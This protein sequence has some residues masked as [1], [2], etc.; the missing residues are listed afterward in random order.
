M[1]TLPKALTDMLEPVVQLERLEAWANK[2]SRRFFDIT[3]YAPENW[4][5]TL[6]PGGGE[7]ATGA[8]GATLV[9]VVRAAFDELE[10]QE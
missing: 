6:Y 5:V 7:D 2:D 9:E 1:S 3:R 4:S 8:F 10:R